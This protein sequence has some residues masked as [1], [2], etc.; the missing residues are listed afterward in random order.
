MLTEDIIGEWPASARGRSRD[1]LISKTL[2][3]H[4]IRA[5]VIVLSFV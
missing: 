4:L 1:D 5:S 2:F 3:S